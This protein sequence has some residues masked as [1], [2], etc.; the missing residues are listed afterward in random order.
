MLKIIIFD[1]KKSHYIY[2]K[3]PNN[4]GI[5]LGD[6]NSYDSIIP[7]D[8][9]EKNEIPS[10]KK[11]NGNSIISDISSV[12]NI[13]IGA[14]VRIFKK[15]NC[16]GK[17]VFIK[18]SSSEGYSWKAA[19][20]D[21]IS[22]SDWPKMLADDEFCSEVSGVDFFITSHYDDSFG[23][24]KD[25]FEYMGKPIANIIATHGCDEI[26]A[27][28]YGRYSQGIKFSDGRRG[29]FYTQMDNNITIEMHDDGRYDI[30]L[31]NP[32]KDVCYINN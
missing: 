21:K 27:S 1:V 5:V 14:D 18:Y 10:L 12:D 6:N 23:V 13:D 9:L 25:L 26:S 29:Y 30:W 11:N 19:I 22:L 3:T 7:F 15:E 28:K 20:A 24:Y 4:Y 2:I 16:P 32:P 31:Q 8:W 17:V